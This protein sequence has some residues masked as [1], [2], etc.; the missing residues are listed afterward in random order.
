[1]SEEQKVSAIPDWVED[2]IT[3][4]QVVGIP[5][6][7]ASYGIMNDDGEKGWSV[8]IASADGIFTHA[9]LRKITGVAQRLEIFLEI[10]GGHP[11]M[12][13]M[14]DPHGRVLAVF[15]NMTSIA[16]D[17]P[18]EGVDDEEEENDQP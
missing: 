6:Y 7:D 18:P 2:V 9:E 12:N 14:M 10:R 1:M 16:G 3:K 13:D 11:R 4:L 15:H 17:K 8:T 5:E